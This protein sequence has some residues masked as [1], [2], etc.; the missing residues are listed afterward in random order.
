MSLSTA[1]YPA[2]AHI[3][4][5]ASPGN[6]GFT[7]FFFFAFLTLCTR[8]V[9]EVAAGKIVGYGTQFAL[10]TLFTLSLLLFFQAKKTRYFRY[11]VVFTCIF[12]ASALISAIMTL[13]R[14]GF[15]FG[16][17]ASLI[18]IYILYLFVVGCGFEIHALSARSMLVVLAFAGIGMTAVALLQLAGIATLPGQS[19]FRPPSTTGSYLHFPLLVTILAGCL[20]Q[21]AISLRRPLYFVAALFCIVGLAVSGSRSGAVVLLGTIGFYSMMQFF[22]LSWR[23]RVRFLLGWCLCVTISALVIAALYNESDSLQRIA[24]FGSVQ[25]RGNIS[26]LETWRWVMDHWLETQF[27]FGEYAGQVGN[28]VGNLSDSDQKVA[29]SGVLQQLI[30]FGVFGLVSFYMTLFAAYPSLSK[31]H[32]M[33]RSL[34]ISAMIQTC[35]YQSTEVFPY[36]ALLALLPIFSRTLEREV[37]SKQRPKAP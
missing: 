24:Q 8:G 7:V 37:E 28:A 17:V 34:Y 16:I 12:A 31:N 3:A 30:N 22:R 2:A 15:I 11:S 6:I 10:W 25:E 35:F 1:S 5:R 32:L 36:M 18:N 9:F 13:E 33:L 26:R 29:E 20:V 21:G 14:D 27:V 4:H 23:L 19:M